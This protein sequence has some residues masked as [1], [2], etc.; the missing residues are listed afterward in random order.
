MISDYGQ[1]L[2]LSLK[3]GVA[4]TGSD[5]VRKLETYSN[6]EAD[7]PS[8][9]NFLETL[10][11][12]IAGDVCKN[13][14]GFALLPQLLRL[15]TLYVSGENSF[16]DELAATLS[17][18]RSFAECVSNPDDWLTG[19]DI[20][21]QAFSDSVSYQDLLAKSKSSEC[22]ENSLKILC[23]LAASL[24]PDIPV[25]VAGQAHSA[26]AH[27]VQYWKDNVRA[28]YEAF[29]APFVESY[30]RSRFGKQR[31]KF[32]SPRSVELALTATT[33]R[34]RAERVEAILKAVVL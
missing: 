8:I 22:Q 34:S 28:L 17:T 2:E 33:T 23:Y 13:A 16:Q 18:Y 19:T 21:E 12:D 6:G 20:M 30:W 32:G 29:V 27:Y 26:V 15:G 14:M 24:K 31:F 10:P 11:M 5:L 3:L 1:V 4:F 25:K 9:K 7:H